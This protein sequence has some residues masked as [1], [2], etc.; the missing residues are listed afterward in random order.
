MYRA[1]AKLY[2]WTDIAK[3][4]VKARSRDL[5]IRKMLRALDEFVIEGV[6]TTIPF[7]RQLLA[8]D[9]FQSG[10]FDTAFL[11]TFKLEPEEP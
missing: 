1:R 8:N 3:L 2:M 9:H 7:H 10:K 5:A 6:K 4:I 11:E